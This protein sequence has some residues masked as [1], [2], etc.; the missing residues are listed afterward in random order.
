MEGNAQ[1]IGPRN[2]WLS[3]NPNSGLSGPGQSRRREIS[4]AFSI[5]TQRFSWSI[6]RQRSH[7]L[8][9]SR[10]S[11]W[12]RFPR[13]D[14]WLD[15]SSLMKHPPRCGGA[16]KKRRRRRKSSYCRG[17]CAENS[18]SAILVMKA[19]GWLAIDTEPLCAA[20]RIALPFTWTRVTAG[21]AS[22][23]KFLKSSITTT[24]GRSR[25]SKSPTNQNNYRFTRSKFAE[26]QPRCLGPRA[27]S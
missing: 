9:T 22:S 24:R 12:C 5:N 14:G 6:F 11:E 26:A 8:P 25:R 21:F 16:P 19:T 4:G 20:A 13:S 2:V 23:P 1:W 17:V 18:D 27:R 10:A 3:P 7:P 15:D